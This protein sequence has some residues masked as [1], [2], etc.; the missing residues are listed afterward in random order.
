LLLIVGSVID[1][2]FA[3]LVFAAISASFNSDFGSCPWCAI[4]SAVRLPLLCPVPSPEP[5]FNK[6]VGT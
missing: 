2:C 3:T 1:S 4:P 5:K 6:I